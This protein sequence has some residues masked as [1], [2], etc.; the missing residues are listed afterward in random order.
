MLLR[1][2]RGDVR[3]C[4][5]CKLV[6]QQGIRPLLGRKA[7]LGMKIVAYLDNDQLNKPTVQNAEVYAVKDQNSSSLTKEELITKYPGVFSD[8]VGLLEGGTISAWISKQPQY[9]TL[10]GVCRWRTERASRSPWTTWR[11]RM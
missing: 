6:D 5:D 8:G 10:L 4:L 7:C 3:C 9:S 2:R 1:V 11:R